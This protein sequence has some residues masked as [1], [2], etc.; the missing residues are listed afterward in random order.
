MKKIC[1]IVVAIIFSASSVYAGEKVKGCGGLAYPPFMWKEGDKIVG[2]GTE[3]ATMIFGE[4]GI[5][6]ESQ[7]FSSWSR[8]MQE[9][10]KGRTD[11]FFA[12]S[13][14][15]DR[16]G[17]ADFTKNPLS[18][19]PTAIFVWKERAFRY[20]KWDD[21]IG[22]KMGKILGTTYGQKFDAFAAKHLKVSKVIKPIQNFR[23]LEKGRV[24]FLPMGLYSGRIQTKQFGYSD[25]VTVLKPYL[26]TG[27]LHIA[28]SKKSKYLKHLPYVDKRLPELHADGTIKRLI[29]KY[30]DYYAATTE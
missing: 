23:K 9:V 20:E 27:Y 17:F 3:V 22:K 8:C 6:I 13:V 29:D 10:R 19:V 28:I 12:A 16:S 1:F 30:I 15:E 18:E 2:V 24:D 11:I 14:N 4:L 25:K 5:D 21:L 7:C 26:K